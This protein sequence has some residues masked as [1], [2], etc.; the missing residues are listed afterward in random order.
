MVSIDGAASIALD[1]F[2]KIVLG[3]S[4][5][6]GQHNPQVPAFI[7]KHQALLAQKPSAFFSVNLVARKPEKRNAQTNPYLKKFL[8]QITWQPKYLAVFAGKIDYPSYTSF[9]RSVIRLIMW[10]TKG[11]TDPTTVREFTDWDEVESFAHVISNM[12]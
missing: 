9:D 6:Y 10:M 5:H 2:D 8:K 11:P 7:A 3:A 4:I 12:R 1:D